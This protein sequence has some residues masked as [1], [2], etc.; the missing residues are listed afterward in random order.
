MN[1]RRLQHYS[2]LATALKEMGMLTVAQG[3]VVLGQEVSSVAVRR[4]LQDLVKAGKAV[5]KGR[6][7]DTRYVWAPHL[8]ASRPVIKKKRQAAKRPRTRVSAG[9]QLPLPFKTAKA[10]E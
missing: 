6:T 3:R 5:R 9:K 7:K 2:V 1:P 10:S 4:I 8:P